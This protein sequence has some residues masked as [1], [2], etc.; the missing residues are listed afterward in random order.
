MYNFDTK[1]PDFT[2]PFTGM[3]LESMDGYSM[4]KENVTIK[5]YSETE[6]TNPATAASHSQ[7]AIQVLLL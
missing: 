6:D 5:E 1:Q 2:I 7:V 3:D 4:S